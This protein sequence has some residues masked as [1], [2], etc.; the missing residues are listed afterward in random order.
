MTV[1]SQDVAFLAG[2]EALDTYGVLVRRTSPGEDVPESYARAGTAP[3]FDP[4]GY[5]RL[6]SANVPRPSWRDLDGDG[7]PETPV[8]PLTGAQDNLVEFNIP[9]GTP[10]DWELQELDAVTNLAGE[11]GLRID[12][13]DNFQVAMPANW[14]PDSF[15]LIGW[16]IPDWDSDD[17]VRHFIGRI[18][19]DSSNQV[20]VSKTTGGDIRFHV[21]AAG[22][23]KSIF[24]TRAFSAGD[25]VFF[26][27]RVYGGTMY[28]YV[29]TDGDGDVT[30][31]VS[32]TADVPAS[33]GTSWTLYVGQDH[34]GNFPL[35]GSLNLIITD[36]GSSAAPITDRF[37]GGDGMAIEEWMNRHSDKLVLGVMGN[38]AGTDYAMYTAYGATPAVTRNDPATQVDWTGLVLPVAVNILRNKHRITTNDS[39]SR[40]VTLLERGFTTRTSAADNDWLSVCWSPELGLF[41]AV[42]YSGTGNRVMTSPDGIT[43]TIRTSAADNDWYSVCWSP[44]LG[45]FCAVAISGSGNR[46]MTSPDGITWTTRTSAADNDWSRSAGVRNLG[47]SAPWRSRASVTG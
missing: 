42:A 26:G 41:C 3:L 47:C 1:R 39:V 22:T 46:V 15:P 5:V 29:D 7:V 35:E 30:D 40:R 36:D 17:G 25:V 19:S 24:M 21:I 43:W 9:G 2:G 14:D 18:H 20:D 6:A 4:D 32:S 28:V 23:I 44:E 27:L 33:T 16:F 13:G 12:A 10:G 37:N 34:E 38:T 45:L 31:N 8:L 11:Y